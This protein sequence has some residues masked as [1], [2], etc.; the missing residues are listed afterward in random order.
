MTQLLSMTTDNYKWEKVFYK[1]PLVV[2]DDNNYSKH[3]CDLIV[4]AKWKGKFTHKDT[5]NW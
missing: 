5:I 1:I 3:Y 4:D 2:F